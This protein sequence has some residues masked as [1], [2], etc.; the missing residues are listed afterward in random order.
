MSGTQYFGV[1]FIYLAI[2]TASWIAM[3]DGE[4]E[5]FEVGVAASSITCLH[6]MLYFNYLGVRR[7][8]DL[9]K[10][11]FFWDRRISPIGEWATFASFFAVGSVLIWTPPFVALAITE[12]NPFGLILG[13][14]FCL[15]LLLMLGSKNTT[16]K[17]EM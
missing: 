3:I 6:G 7:R 10:F 2:M 17:G 1:A 13:L 5:W 8:H 14:F 16:A 4:S 15:P 9:R 12:Q 11:N